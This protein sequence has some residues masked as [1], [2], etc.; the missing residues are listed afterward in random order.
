MGGQEMSDPRCKPTGG[1]SRSDVQSQMP[2]DM[3]CISGA[4][5]GLEG[6]RNLGN[7]L[8]GAGRQLDGASVARYHGEPKCCLKRFHLMTDGGLG[9]SDRSGGLRDAARLRQ[10]D[11]R[12]QS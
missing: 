1:K 3:G 2:R 10:A 7:V 8:S 6:R 12:V 5:Q 11:K 4:R 9:Q